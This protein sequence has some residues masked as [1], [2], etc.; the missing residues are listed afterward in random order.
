MWIIWISKELVSHFYARTL[1][2]RFLRVE[3][4]PCAQAPSCTGEKVV[5][6]LKLDL[7]GHELSAS[8]PGHFTSG[9]R[10]IHN[11]IVAYIHCAMCC[12]WIAKNSGCVKAD[13]FSLIATIPKTHREKEP[14][15]N[16]VWRCWEWHWY[17]KTGVVGYS[18][19]ISLYKYLQKV[20]LDNEIWF[21]LWRKQR[22][23]FWDGYFT[24]YI[25]Y[26]QRQMS[27]S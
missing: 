16:C 25:F 8:H 15:W 4:N 6:I 7:S 23:Q 10:A 1:K 21:E 19:S 14:F 24:T 12:K 13:L 2:I 17:K 11:S 9:E 3:N 22:H 20:K 27:C 5:S 18:S 26:C